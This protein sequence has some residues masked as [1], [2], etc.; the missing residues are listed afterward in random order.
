VPGVVIIVIVM[1]LAIPVAI[2]LGGAVWSAIVG[3]LLVDDTE[4]RDQAGGAP[5][6]A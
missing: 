2:M 5:E 6:Q 3:W 4:R 1:V